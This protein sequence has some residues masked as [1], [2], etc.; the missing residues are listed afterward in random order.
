MHDAKKRKAIVVL[1]RIAGVLEKCGGPGGKLGPCPIKFT[2][3]EHAYKTGFEH[4]YLGKTKANTEDRHYKNGHAQGRGL[5][6]DHEQDGRQI[7]LDM[8]DVHDHFK[9]YMNN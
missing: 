3:V 4:G 7:R 1:E 2:S 9:N 5:R 6:D 8:A